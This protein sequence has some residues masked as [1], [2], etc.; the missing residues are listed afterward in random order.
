MPELWLE[1]LA[2]EFW[3]AAG[4]VE[5]F[6]RDLEPSVLWALPI[7]ILK[8]PQ[9]TVSTVQQWLAQRNILFSVSG[10]NRHL[11]ACLIA[12]GGNGLILLAG[13]DSPDEIRF[14][15]AH[16]T[17]H[18]IIDYLAPRKIAHQRIGPAIL[19]VLD[20]YRLPTPD[21]RGTALLSS[22]S[23]GVYQHLM[24]RSVDG[25][26][27]SSGVVRAEQ[28]ADHLALELLAPEATVRAIIKRSDGA[29]RFSRLE[30][31][32]LLRKQF[33]LPKVAA[34]RY[35]YQFVP[36]PRPQSIKEWLGID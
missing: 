21:E 7:A 15:L 18:F 4:S 27:E 6:P 2:A 17:A 11:H 1:R 8:L 34:I 5:P 12:F 14:S 32:N 22:T 24:G 30:I 16:E 23:I 26:I 20:G 10:R 36:I 3:Q 9:L 29:E 33:G 19:E 35:S 25:H 28:R 31:V 13:R